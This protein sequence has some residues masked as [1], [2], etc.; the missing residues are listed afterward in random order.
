MIRWVILLLPLLAVAACADGHP[1]LAEA[2]GP[3]RALN[4]GKW[5][6]TP[7]DLRGPRLPLPPSLSPSLNV[8]TP[9]S[10]PAALGWRG[11]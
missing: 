1:P 10:A 4:P 11:S 8:A 6:P 9:E 5:T 7:D 2:S 3:Y